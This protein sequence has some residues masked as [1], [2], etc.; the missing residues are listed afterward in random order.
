MS[1]KRKQYSEVFKAKVAIEAIKE[2]KTISEIASIY[3]V[4]PVVVKRWKKQA[5]E[6]LPDVFS[7]KQ[8]KEKE[9][10]QALEAEL[11]RQIGQLKV[12]ID[13]L[14]KKSEILT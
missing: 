11:Y 9:E 13:W 8:L 5:L 14:K 10:S 4:H 6:Q 7:K 3:E 12:E 2:L 1:S